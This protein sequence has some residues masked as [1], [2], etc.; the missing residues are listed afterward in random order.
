MI[1]LTSGGRL[2]PAYLHEWH[3]ESRAFENMAGWLD[4]RANLTGSGEPREV[5][6][7]RTTSNFFEVLGTPAQLGR[8]FTT[9]RDLSRVEAE[10]VLSHG[11]W[12]RV[13]G[14]AS[15][16][17]GRAMVLDGQVVTVVGVMPPGFTVRTNELAE[18]RAEL[19]MP[20]P[21]VPGNRVGMGGFLNVVARVGPNAT[22]EE[23]RAE[24]ATI[25]RRIEAAYPSYS[26]DWGVLVVPLLDATVKDVRPTLIVLFGAV[27]LLLVIACVNVANLVLSRGV[28]RHAE[29]AVRLSIGATKSRVV[30]Q[31][32][33][34]NLV[35]A[36]IGG[37][38]SVVCA[39][40][41]T[42]LVVA[43]IPP[44]LVLPRAGDI[45]VSLRV[46]GFAA[47][48]T[49]LV[50]VLFGMAPA[51]SS[52]RFEAAGL[53]T[54]AAQMSLGR[55]HNA[56]GGILIVSQ[57]ALALVLLAG[58]G[59]LTR[60]YWTLTAVDPGFKA[61]QVI[62]MRTTLSASIYS[63]DDRIRQFGTRLL[64]GLRGLPEL[65]AVGTANYLP[66][67]NFGVAARFEIAAPRGGHRGPALRVGQRR[68]RRLLQGDGDPARSRPASYTR[69]HRED[70]G[71]VRRRRGA[72]T[73]ALDRG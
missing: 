68:R 25:A 62:S 9:S 63:T 19:W 43:S 61:E 18:S 49:V 66:M 15:T 26:R 30:R 65:T 8:T 46:L 70:A 20:F 3:A 54:A 1:R 45:G 24:L 34:E 41:G 31:L 47:V 2:S 52:A 14:G 58:A 72:C 50:S 7:D 53:R 17:V 44:G 39:V 22:L 28:S 71:R 10:L 38:L 12:Q 4:V 40:F 57:V 51:L 6:V 69:R 60:T 73:P 21:L 56:L 37:A 5:L 16:V 64:D 42:E 48:V 13:Y 36:G 55:R 67:S 23:G 32:L 27:G 35:L 11:L 33:A 59:L 29:I